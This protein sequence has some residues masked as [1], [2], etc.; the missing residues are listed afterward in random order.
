MVTNSDPLIIQEDA[1][2]PVLIL[3]VE[4]TTPIK[5]VGHDGCMAP[6]NLAGNS[7]SLSPLMASPNGQ[8]AAEYDS[9]DSG[10]SYLSYGSPNQQQCYKSPVSSRAGTPPPE[11]PQLLNRAVNIMKQITTD[12]QR[13]LVQTAALRQRAAGLKEQARNTRDVVRAERGRR[14]RLEAYFT[15]WR[16]IAPNWP[17][18]WIYEEGEE[19]QMRTER[20]LKTMTPPLP[21]TGPTGPPTLPFDGRDAPNSHRELRRRQLQPRQEA[22][23]QKTGAVAPAAEVDQSGQHIN[24]LPL[25][26]FTI[27]GRAAKRKYC[28]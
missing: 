21:S 8:P 22:P 26:Q 4:N 20:V 27:K 2:A 12:D 7:P 1:P 25:P 18:D 15:Y 16:E 6:G 14:E 13:I 10:G 28:S 19:D 23:T 17:K 24:R 9:S 3:A 11:Q 5:A